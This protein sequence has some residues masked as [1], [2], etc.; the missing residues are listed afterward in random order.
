MTTEKKGL[1][2]T[3]PAVAEAAAA[4]S[5]AAVEGA[6]TQLPELMDTNENVS[7]VKPAATSLVPA[8]VS[9]TK[10]RYVYAGTNTG[11]VGNLAYQSMF[12]VY[13]EARFLT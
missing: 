9:V 11:T 6:A 3:P 1:A 13:S 2:G 7:K 10:P 8:E 4:S 5:S 12:F